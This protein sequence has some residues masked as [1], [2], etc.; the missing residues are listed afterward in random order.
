MNS[1][2]AVVDE[3]AE[4]SFC[5]FPQ[6]YFGT[7]KDIETIIQIM[8]Q[9]NDY[10]S[11]VAAW[12]EYQTGNQFASHKVA[13]SSSPLLR[14]ATFIT[15]SKIELEHITWEHTNI[16]NFVYRMKISG[17]SVSQIILEY[18]NKYYRCLRAILKDL[19]YQSDNGDW[20]EIHDFSGNYPVMQEE[21][22]SDGHYAISNLLYV[23]EDVKDSSDEFIKLISDADAIQFDMFCDEIFADG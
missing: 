19:K 15:T 13:F 4:V 5:S 3:P 6:P 18:E 12:K 17:G 7:L 11:T 16:W 21:K 23:V 22:L 9:H 10:D 8:E 14:P 1:I 2:V 20:N